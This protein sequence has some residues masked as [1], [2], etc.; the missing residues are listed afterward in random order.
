MSFP[1]SR[2]NKVAQLKIR[3]GGAGTWGYWAARQLPLMFQSLIACR[4]ATCAKGSMVFQKITG[5]RVTRHSLRPCQSKKSIRT[6]NVANQND[7]DT[8]HL[9]SM[10]P[11]HIATLESLPPICLETRRLPCF[12]RNWN[13]SVSAAIRVFTFVC[14]RPC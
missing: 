12:Q 11:A 1:T 5:K 10:K 14:R 2:S 6:S 7:C 9:S 8:A 4:V 3:N 13:P